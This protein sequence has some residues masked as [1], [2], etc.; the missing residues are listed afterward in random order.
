MKNPETHCFYKHSSISGTCKFFSLW[1][2]GSHDRH[3]TCYK[4]ATLER[5]TN[6]PLFSIP[7]CCYPAVSATARNKLM[8]AWWGW[9]EAA[10]SCFMSWRSKTFACRF[11]PNGQGPI[12]LADLMKCSILCYRSPWSRIPH[13]ILPNAHVSRI[14]FLLT[15]RGPGLRVLAGKKNNCATRREAL[16]AGSALWGGSLEAQTEPDGRGWVARD[17]RGKGGVTL[18]F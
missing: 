13:S 8:G 12:Y 16:G 1:L 7:N 3:A 4:T 9:D 11:L 14:F 10:Q 2:F 5:R 18:P 6:M 17:K 15:S